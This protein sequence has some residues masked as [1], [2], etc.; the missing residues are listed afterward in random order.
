MRTRK[1][2]IKIPEQ[3]CVRTL[4][5]SSLQKIFE[6]TTNVHINVHMTLFEY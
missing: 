6:R 2:G 4:W 5:M 1:G 3:N